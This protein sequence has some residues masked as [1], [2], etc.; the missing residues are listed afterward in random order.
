MLSKLVLC[1]P[2]QMRPGFE[3]VKQ[4][5]YKPSQLQRMPLTISWLNFTE[6]Q[7]AW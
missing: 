1:K 4:K 6:P 5:R 3:K 7:S 2:P